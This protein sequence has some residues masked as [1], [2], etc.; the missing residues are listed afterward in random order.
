MRQLTPTAVDPARQRGTPDVLVQLA[1]RFGK[2]GNLDGA[3]IAGGMKSHAYLCLTSVVVGCGGA[4]GE[5]EG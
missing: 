1:E 5:A 3:F 2:L 4:S